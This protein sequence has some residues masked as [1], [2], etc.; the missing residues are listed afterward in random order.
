MTLSELQ[1]RLE[2]VL[3]DLG[4]GD[5]TLKAVRVDI[6][7]I[8]GDLAEDPGAFIKLMGRS[9]SE[10][11]AWRRRAKSALNHKRKESH[12]LR[13]RMR[14]LRDEQQRLENLISAEET[15]YRG[16][17]PMKL[18]AAMTRVLGSV[19]RESGYRLTDDQEG[20]MNAAKASL[21]L[22]DKPFA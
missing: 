17:D 5:E 13:N 9:P 11:A 2:E 12:S 1:E 4:Y 22:L 20:V 10:Y 19:C 18:L 21:G 8:T 6:A 14:D 3:E 15:S 7:R 16:D